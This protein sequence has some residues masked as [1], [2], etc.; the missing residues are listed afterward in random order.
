MGEA[1]RTRANRGTLAAAVKRS[2]QKQ[3][4][5][6]RPG[7][8]YP[9]K[10][11]TLQPDKGMRGGSCNREAC[12]APGATYYNFGTHKWY[13]P[14]CAH[15]I[16]T[17]RCNVQDMQEL[18]GGPILVPEEVYDTLTDE[19]RAY[20]PAMAKKRAAMRAEQNDP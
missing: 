2:Y 8:N 7:L 1:K 6:H 20:G 16:N 18:Y 19:E 17:D 12:Q 10:P 11:V 4:G 5:R 13:C 9:G 3:F 14:H 15:L